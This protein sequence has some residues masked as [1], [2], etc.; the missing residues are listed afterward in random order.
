MTCQ[1]KLNQDL[2]AYA[3]VCEER[4]RMGS[5]ERGRSPSTLSF[6][7]RGADYGGTDY[8]GK[9]LTLRSSLPSDHSRRRD[10]ESK[11]QGRMVEAMTYA[12][13]HAADWYVLI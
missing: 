2:W 13:V 9:R 4:W 10:N 5:Y 11:S 7:R 12:A 3:L 1:R 6:D 8:G